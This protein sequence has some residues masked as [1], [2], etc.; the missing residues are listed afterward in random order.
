MKRFNTP[1]I[2]HLIKSQWTQIIFNAEYCVCCAQYCIHADD[3]HGHKIYC[4]FAQTE[5][6]LCVYAVHICYCLL[7]KQMWFSVEISI[8]N[9]SYD[10]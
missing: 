10:K 6:N 8:W 7:F 3:D 1:V 2:S 4:R 5:L 9:I